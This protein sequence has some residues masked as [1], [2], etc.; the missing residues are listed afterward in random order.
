MKKI[1]LLT[2]IILVSKLIQGQ[3]DSNS[4]HSGFNNRNF[5]FKFDLLS[6][7]IG[8]EARLAKYSTFLFAYQPTVVVSK[9][10]NEPVKTTI[11]TQF[12]ASTRFFYNIEKRNISGKTTE[13]FSGNFISLSIL[14]GILSSSTYIVFAPTWGLQR[15]W[16]KWIHFSFELG[17]GITDDTESY[18]LPIIPYA[19]VKF[20]VSI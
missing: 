1:L 5:V 20:G 8:L 15:N 9:H 2:C 18:N 16:G 10:L 6:P 17:P 7:A 13:K 14:A 19:E 4:I 11:L 12:R 3:T